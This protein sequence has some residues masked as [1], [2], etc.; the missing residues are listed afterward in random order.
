MAPKLE[1]IGISKV[2]PGGTVANDGSQSF[3]FT[4][5]KCMPLSAKMAPANPP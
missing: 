4:P 3:P 1:A 2:Y 5:A